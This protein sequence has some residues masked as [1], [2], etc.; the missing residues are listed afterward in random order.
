MK[1][2]VSCASWPLHAVFNSSRDVMHTG[3]IVYAGQSGWT[4]AAA[5]SQS[6]DSTIKQTQ[7]TDNFGLFLEPVTLW[8][9]LNSLA[10]HL[11][12]LVPSFS[13]PRWNCQPLFRTKIAALTRQTVLLDRSH[14]SSKYIPSFSVRPKR[15]DMGGR[16]RVGWPMG[17]V[18][19]QI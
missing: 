18:R 15:L 19:I 12:E 6:I 5:N 2:D 11:V 4:C 9:A 10:C 17:L 1:E 8:F 7:I 13:L 14:Q 3:T 16:E